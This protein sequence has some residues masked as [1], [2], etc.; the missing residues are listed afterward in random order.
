M[1]KYIVIFIFTIFLV[2]GC[3]K[4]YLEVPN[5][6][7]GTSEDYWKTEKSLDY[8]STGCYK[9]LEQSSLKETSSPKGLYGC[10]LWVFADGGADCINSRGQNPDRKSE[11]IQ[12]G[13]QNPG[14]SLLTNLWQYNYYLIRRCNDLI[15]NAN[16]VPA[17]EVTIMKTDN[18]V[19]EAKFIRAL[20]YFN[21]IRMFGGRPHVAAEDVWGVPLMTASVETGEDLIK[22]RSKVSEVY[23]LIIADLTFAINNLPD[24]WPSKH[25]TFD[26]KGRAVKAS[27]QAL[28]AKVYMTKAGTSGNSSDWTNAS[29][30]ADLVIANTAYGL[31]T[32]SV[33]PFAGNPYACLFR[34]DSNGENSIESLFEVQNANDAPGYYGYGENYNNFL[35]MSSSIAANNKGS[36]HPDSTFVRTYQAGDLRKPA[37]IFTKGDVF[38]PE[39]N[40]GLPLPGYTFNGVSST[41]YACKKFVSGKIIYDM[42]ETGPANPRVLRFAEVLL[43]KAEAVNEISGPA[44][45]YQY[46]NQ[47][48]NR[49]GLNNLDATST[50]DKASM[51]AAIWNERKRELFLE[52]DRW[53][54]LKRTDQLISA[55]LANN[56][57]YGTA[58]TRANFSGSTQKHYIMPIPAG[59]INATMVDGAPVLVQAPEY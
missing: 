50:P 12:N 33:A 3:G 18:Y 4:D 24:N 36:F 27:A 47:V 57:N 21:L 41:K 54:D 17:T 55:M 38:Y 15:D 9:W 1:K 59:D 7:A 13:N 32:S 49:S 46:I 35:A 22:P 25:F 42:W 39:K 10:V 20:G 45:A 53:F 31:F 19:A 14:T 43:I 30:N 56:I 29:N 37:C 16:K 51:R 44:N 40:G 52:A 58:A 5:Y 28:L 48:R 11:D 8:A 34:I 2:T 26:T 23:D 6:G